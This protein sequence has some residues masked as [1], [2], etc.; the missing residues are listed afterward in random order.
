MEVMDNVFED[1]PGFFV[2]LPPGFDFFDPASLCLKV[3]DI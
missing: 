1:G 3:C 2:E